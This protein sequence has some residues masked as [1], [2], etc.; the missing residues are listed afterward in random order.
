MYECKECGK[1]FKL[2]QGVKTHVYM[3]HVLQV[4]GKDRT[5]IE[6]K[7]DKCGDDKLY[8]NSEA[9]KQHYIAKHSGGV[10]ERHAGSESSSATESSLHCDICMAPIQS[11]D[12]HMKLFQPIVL[13]TYECCNCG[14]V[15]GSERA[16]TQHELFCDK[17]STSDSYYDRSSLVAKNT[18]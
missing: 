3:T 2:E 6:L 11:M 14:K 4:A 16:L 1:Q 8:P 13:P 9:L 17:K 12:E 7:C 15:L 10:P 18:E 5:T